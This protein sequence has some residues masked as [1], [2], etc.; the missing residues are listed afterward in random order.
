M[1]IRL[2][3]AVLVVSLL[4]LS[5]C[6]A[7]TISPVD[8]RPANVAAGA[9]NL[10]LI[11]LPGDQSAV[12]TDRI[13][14]AQHRIIMTMYLLSDNDVIQALITAADRGVTV[15]VLLERA[16]YGGS[17][18]A[19]LTYDVLLRS[20]VAVRYASTYYR[21]THQKSAVIDETAI[22]LTANLTES[23]LHS[24]REFGVLSTESA[25]VSEIVNAFDAD[26]NRSTFKPASPHLVWSP[27]NA[28]ERLSNVISATARTLLAYAEE[29]QDDHQTQL[30]A[31][32]A[33]HG[34]D[35]RL[36]VSPPR[37]GADDA[38]KVDLDILQRAGVRVRYLAKPYIHAKAFIVDGKLAFLGSQNLTATSLEFN[39]ELGVLIS[40]S[41]VISEMSAVFREDWDHAVDR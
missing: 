25:D 41:A 38:N 33:L 26:W 29:V 28:R 16:P 17:A 7:R 35:I 1:K 5:A 37:S 31:E 8:N 9:R 18:S 2:Q 3:L 14:K 6:P 12:I 34:E 13:A 40:D 11:V 36:L 39:R 22:I 15:R 30:L 23:G 24:N 20:R 19:Q 27:Q 4:L 21:F 10:Q 32:Q